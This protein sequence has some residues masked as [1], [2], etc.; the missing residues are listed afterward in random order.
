[1]ARVSF[2]TSLAIGA[3][4]A[5]MGL[6][7]SASAE[8]AKPAVTPEGQYADIDRVVIS[9]ATD[10]GEKRQWVDQSEAAKPDKP[11]LPEIDASS[12][13]PTHE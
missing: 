3:G 9:G 8:E 10:A 12:W 5:A 7:A 1:M 11:T 6:A 4:L 13:L 2:I